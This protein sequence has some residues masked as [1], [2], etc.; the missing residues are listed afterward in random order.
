MIELLR[1]ASP[2]TISDYGKKEEIKKNITIK[3][4]RKF[5]WCTDSFFSIIIVYIVKIVNFNTI[6]LI[7]LGSGCLF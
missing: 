6:K 7:N 2:S 4:I 5:C 3:R 1:N